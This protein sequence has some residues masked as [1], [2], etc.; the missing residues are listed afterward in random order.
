[1]LRYEGG[2]HVLKLARLALVALVV[3][4][5]VWLSATPA[6]A[7][8]KENWQVTFSGTGVVPGSG[9]GFGFWGWCGLGGGVTSG[10]DADC[11]FAQ[12]FHAPSGSGFTCHESL[13]INAWD[14]TGGTFVISGKV[15]VTPTSLTDACLSLFPGS[16]TFTN[17][18]LGI[19]AA[20]GHYN[21]GGIGGVR[22][23]FQV[24]VTQVQ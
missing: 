9:V 18:D 19:R 4:S 2:L 24:Q 10:D 14:T 8:G 21:L 15:T 5:F 16:A 3:V 7:Y 23:E 6:S 22:G 1:M 13:D 20:S 17:V 12:Y 11:Q